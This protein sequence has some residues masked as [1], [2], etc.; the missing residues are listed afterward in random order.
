MECAK[1]SSWMLKFS[2]VNIVS[3]AFLL[4]TGIVTTETGDWIQ[5]K[6]KEK[7]LTQSQLA[8]ELGIPQPKV[9]QLE[10]GVIEPTDAQ[11]RILSKLLSEGNQ[12]DDDTLGRRRSGK[13]MTWK[14]AVTRV[15]TDARASMHY[16]D[17]ADE[18]VSKGYRK[19]VGAT[20]ANTVATIITNEI[21]NKGNESVFIRTGYGEY[22]L[23]EFTQSDAGQSGG[24]LEKETSDKADESK[25]IVNA[26]GMYW[27]REYVDWSSSNVSLLGV[28]QLGASQVDFAD[29]K[30]VYL[31]HD[32]RAVVYVGRATDQSLGKR[33]YQH[34]I[35]RLN[36]RWDRFSWFG[37]LHV[38]EEG[39]LS[40]PDTS[41][42]GLD[43]WVSMMEALL[44][45]GLEPPQNRRRGDDFRAVE[46]LQRKDP[47]IGRREME[48]FLEKVKST[49]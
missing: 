12:D 21:R 10:R 5:I 30:G 38:S 26:F 28:Q 17:I 16:T 44:I 37:V 3:S 4:G 42:Y 46:Y 15:L 45:E 9:S 14:D 35:D 36:G 22:I 7:R 39:E 27:R 19:D 32:G 24:T 23:R 33:L 29:Q 18:I 13:N 20:P 25:G 40:E 8:A 11:M 6:R 41:S 2:S 34:T 47:K 43:D 48:R 1:K 31:L 49:M